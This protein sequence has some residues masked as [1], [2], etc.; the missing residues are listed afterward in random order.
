MV[1]ADASGETATATRVTKI[2]AAGNSFLAWTTMSEEDKH[3]EDETKRMAQ[4][5]IAGAA[6]A[7]RERDA[8]DADGPE[9]EA[10]SLTAT[11]ALSFSIA[12]PQRCSDIAQASTFGNIEPR[13]LHYGVPPEEGCEESTVVY[14]F[15]PR[16]P[17]FQG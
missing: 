7:K 6:G 11:A 10:S 17:C 15:H 9:S 14:G 1:R 13:V 16:E 12:T 5:A 2:Q 8:E 3:A 4:K